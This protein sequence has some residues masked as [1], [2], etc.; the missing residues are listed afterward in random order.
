MNPDFDSSGESLSQQII[1][2]LMVLFRLEP[3][4]QGHIVEKVQFLHKMANSK[5][6]H[7]HRAIIKELK[8]LYDLEGSGTEAQILQWAKFHKDYFVKDVISAWNTYKEYQHIVEPLE[9]PAWRS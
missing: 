8:E 6:A 5:E 7:M 4:Q 3:G 2:E 9:N 1:S